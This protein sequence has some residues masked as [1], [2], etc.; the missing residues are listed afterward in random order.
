[1]PDF[2]SQPFDLCPKPKMYIGGSVLFARKGRFVKERIDVWGHRHFPA[3]EPGSW[4]K[5]LPAD[6]LPRRLQPLPKEGLGR[7][8]QMALWHSFPAPFPWCASEC[9]VLERQATLVFM[10]GFWVQG[11][12]LKR[13]SADSERWAA[14]QPAPC[15][16]LCQ[17]TVPE[18]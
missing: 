13:H 12:E 16:G 6:Q 7:Y 11:A 1:M 9:S 2:F 4:G 8:R 17:K 15:P 14:E 5:H 18:E 3:P 10:V